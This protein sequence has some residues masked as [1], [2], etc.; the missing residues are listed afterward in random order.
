MIA[1]AE[2]SLILSF[3]PLTAMRKLQ[4]VSR[5][6]A[7]HQRCDLADLAPGAAAGRFI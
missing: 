4:L 5:S 6:R 2:I 7:L 1:R 3:G